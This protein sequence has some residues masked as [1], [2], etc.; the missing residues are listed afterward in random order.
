[1]IAAPLKNIFKAKK[2]RDRVEMGVRLDFNEVDKLMGGATPE[3]RRR[4]MTCLRDAIQFDMSWLTEEFSEWNVPKIEFVVM[5]RGGKTL[6]DI[7]TYLGQ[8]DTA[9]Y[10]SSFSPEDNIEEGV[11]GEAR[12]G[13][14]SII[15]AFMTA[16]EG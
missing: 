7:N 15:V 9:S 4:A 14:R 1:L 8:R 6:R 12:A 2:L 10:C 16:S 5:M 3:S 13:N 11:S